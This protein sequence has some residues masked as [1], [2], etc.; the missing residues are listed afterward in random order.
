VDNE[1]YILIWSNCI[2]STHNKVVV[3]NLTKPIGFNF[4]S[5]MSRLLAKCGSLL[6]TSG[7]ITFLYNLM[8]I[9][10]SPKVHGFI[11]W[12][13]QSGRQGIKYGGPFV[14]KRIARRW[15]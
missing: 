6:L 9:F 10:N 5:N 4:R 13:R 2:D 15:P 1:E 14:D 3:V 8:A 11:C 7:L 12:K